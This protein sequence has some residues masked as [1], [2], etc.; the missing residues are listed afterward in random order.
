MKIRGGRP[1]LQLK[2][3]HLTMDPLS[4][5]LD[6]V[7]VNEA[8]SS[9]SSS[10]PL[11]AATASSTIMSKENTSGTS[12]TALSAANNNNANI[13]FEPPAACIRR[14]LKQTLPKSTNVSKDS[15]CAISRASGIF[16]LYLTACAN[17][18]AREGRR[19]TI[20]AK[21][22]LGALCECNF[23]DFLPVMNA[24][25][26]AYRK[27]ELCKKEASK[28]NKKRKQLEGEENDSSKGGGGGGKDDTA[29]EGQQTKTIK[30]VE[31]TKDGGDN[32]DTTMAEND[33]SNNDE[34]DK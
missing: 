34:H 19:T 18:I 23:E 17:D 25:L 28:N 26:D 5:S 9:A 30:E 33:N 7:I 2:H 1:E 24:F 6:D 21:D 11:E 13:E 29:D 32:N 8:P 16:I 15:L 4:S 3:T 31:S 10:G 22:V 20:V 14:L 12:T 27:E